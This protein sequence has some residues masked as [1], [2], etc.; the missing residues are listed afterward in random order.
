[1][2]IQVIGLRAWQQ[3]LAVAEELHFGRAALRLNMTQPPLTQAIARLEEQLGVRLFIRTSRR[4]ELTPAAECLIDD[5]RELLARAQALP[6]RAR[7]IAAGETGRIRMGFV[8]TVG[9]AQLPSWVRSYRAGHPSVALELVELTGDAQLTA[10]QRGEIDVGIVLHAPGQ[11]PAGMA[12][13][14]ISREAFALA[15][16]ADHVLGTAIEVPWLQVLREPLIVFPRRIAASLHDAIFSVY[17]AFDC[18]P[19]VAQEAIQMQ[20]IVNLVSGGMGIA[21]VPWSVTAF[22][23]PGVVYRRI[24]EIVSPTHLAAAIDMPCC[25]VSLVWLP[26]RKH[27]AVLGLIDSIK[28]ASMQAPKGGS[29]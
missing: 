8:S 2:G 10:L 13:R 21:W 4:V 9:F 3:F 5:V 18:I 19:H 14:T 1:M 16:P 28:P 26:E 29:S 27:P 23:R 17:E 7:S 20:T 24:E 12:N 6:G 15:L 25:E 11:V 22:G